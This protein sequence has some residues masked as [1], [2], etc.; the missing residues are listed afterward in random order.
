MRRYLEELPI[1][2]TGWLR[3]LRDPLIGRALALLHG[4][5]A[6]PWTL[7][8]L[9]ETLGTSR[10]VLA[11]RFTRLV[12]Q[13]PLQYLTRWRVQLAASMLKETNAKVSAV[14]VDVGYS[15]EAAF[16]RAFKKFAGVPPSK[17]RQG[18]CM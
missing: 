6:H 10:T 15:S 12:G 1:E 2:Q 5:P 17:W 9:A 3:G 18:R 16:S 8:D 14:A 13:A 7:V 11:D 4:N